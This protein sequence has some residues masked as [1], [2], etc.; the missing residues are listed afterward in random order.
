MQAS[1]SAGMVIV[2]AGHCG[3][4][5]AQALREAGWAGPIHLV[6]ME[7]HAPYERPPLSKELLTGE[8]TAEDCQL[9]SVQAMIDDDIHLHTQRVSSI[10]TVAHCIALANGEVL[11]YYRL[12]LATGGGAR[13]L[14]IPGAELPEVL[15]L[16]TVDD[17]LLLAQRLGEGRRLL[18]IGGGFIG[19]EVAAS[20]RR[21][22][23]AVTLLEGAS[24]LL[25][26]TV[27]ADVAASVHALHQARGV[28][29]RLGMLPTA[30][31]P[32]FPC[33][34]R[35]HLSDG[36]HI[37]TD[38]VVVGIGMKP[39][40][41]LARAAGLAV[42]QGILVDAHLRTSAPDVF[43][44]GDVAEFPGPLSDQPMRQETWFNAETQ[45]W[46]AARNM[47]CDQ[48]DVMERVQQ[49]PWFW[50]DQYD[51][52]LQVCGEPAL[53]THTVK[54]ELGEGM[55]ITFHLDEQNR[56][57]GMSAWGVTQ[58]C[59]KDFKLA[60]MLVERRVHAHPEELRDPAVK[61]KALVSG[62]AVAT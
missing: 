11:P 46:V 17:A 44:A 62:M 15:T 29:V 20:A 57:V 19:L 6:G 32:H 26:R 60:R 31:V 16:R 52:Q 35:V 58:K 27:P 13:C 56:A 34:V 59:L 3:G 37:D 9:R 51:H 28:D 7:H 21:T 22:G 50:S 47:L 33:G 18:V 49:A 12:L 25:G 1:L 4:R 54:R 36:S 39:A 24:R 41:E 53:G 43:A 45:A 38:T 5:A 14:D 2:G 61:L 30:I 10:D 42:A 40:T 8:K 55:H 48:T 23:M